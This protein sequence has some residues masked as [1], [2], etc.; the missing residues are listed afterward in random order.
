VFAP[1]AWAL[2]HVAPGQSLPPFVLPDLTGK[3]VSRDSLRGSPS[4]II[5]WSTW[6]PRSAEALEDFKAY[7]RE[8]G[9]RGLKVLAVNVDGEHLSAERKREIREYASRMDLP[10]PVL[11]D[12]DLAAFAAYGVMAHPSLVVAGPDLAITYLLGGYPLSLR[13]ELRDAFLALLGPPPGGSPPPAPAAP[14]NPPEADTPARRQHLMGMKLLSQGQTDRAR[15]AFRRAAAEDPGYPDPAVMLARVSLSVGESGP[16]ENLLAGL[17]RE[18]VRRHDLDYLAGLLALRSGREGEAE[19]IFRGL[20]T[21]APQQA[22]GDWGLGLLLLARNDVPGALAH[23][24]KAAAASPVNVEAEALVKDFL[25]AA[26]RG[27]SPVP[28]EGRL[29]ALFPSLGEMRNRYRNLFRMREGT[30]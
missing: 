29:V 20:L 16:A 25:R 4:V 22:W 13:E 7:H 11:L 21:G 27:G 17:D 23:L 18:Q 6:S 10:F 14:V 9:P 1:P 5:F 8:Q 28:E 26:W 12:E 3:T 24:E 15:E 30:P 19:A 2:K